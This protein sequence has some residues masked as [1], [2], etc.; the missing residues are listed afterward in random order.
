MSAWR[1]RGEQG[2]TL[3]EVLVAFLIAALALGVLFRGAVEGQAS[4]AVAARYQEAISR[5]RSRLA[6]LDATPPVPGDQQGD[7]GGGYRWRVRTTLLGTA[8]GDPPPALYGIA[9]AITWSTGGQ[10]RVFQLN[11][12]RLGTAPPAPP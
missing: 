4:A 2:F 11:T 7:D 5:A 9:V 12:R 10:D 1:A 3:L 8:P 6:A